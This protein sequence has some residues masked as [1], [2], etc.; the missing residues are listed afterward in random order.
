MTGHH[1]LYV[2]LTPNDSAQDGIN[3]CGFALSQGEVTSWGQMSTYIR[4]SSQAHADDT[5]PMIDL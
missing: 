1:I 2:A 3:D 4:F 5:N